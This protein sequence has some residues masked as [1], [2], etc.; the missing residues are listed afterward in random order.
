MIY[1]FGNCQMEFLGNALAELGMES[2][3]R[4]MATPLGPLTSQGR[5]PADLLSW[6]SR[7]DLASFLHGR[8]LKNQ[9]LGMSPDD[10]APSLMVVNLFHENE[11]LFG[12]ESGY[13]FFVDPAAW[14]A[15]PYFEA[16]MKDEFQQV[17][18]SEMEYLNRWARFVSALR[19][20]YPKT[21]ILLATQLSH[22][23][24]F[25]PRPYSYLTC[26]DKV[27]DRA[28]PFLADLAEELGNCHVLDA[29]R[30]FA[31]VW[32][33]AGA[34]APT[35][36][37]TATD[38][39]AHCPF[40]K[41]SITGDGGG[42]RPDMRRDLE[43][44]G[45]LWPAMAAKVAHFMDTGSLS[46]EEVES[47]PE[48]W[49]QPYQPRPL[50]VSQLRT[51]LASGSNYEGARAVNG[52]FHDLGNDHSGLLAEAAQVMPVCHGTLH[53]VHRYAMLRP[54]PGLMTWCMAQQQKAAAFTA[55]GP[56]YQRR[57][58]ERLNEIMDSVA[59]Q[60]VAE[61]LGASPELNAS[62]PVC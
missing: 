55:N 5:I 6:A 24:A 47:I 50:P 33:G 38:M 12:H 48:E 2:D 37:A 59:M 34:E 15:E 28:G 57:Y 60:S 17:K 49:H 27:W 51:L 19:Q 32:N 10:P 30:L 13:L 23:P 11:P 62:P 21:P 1:L 61:H 56:E 45:S 41:I 35:E 9:F 44:V 3:H 18:L 42:P 14:T 26:W 54:G 20:A 53:M 29:D 39:D 36:A 31:G 43:H 16:W 22:F 46:W 52:F 4:P 7:F 25:G 58:C 8:T 40:L